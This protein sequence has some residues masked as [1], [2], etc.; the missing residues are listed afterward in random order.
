MALRP[1]IPEKR[2]P[3]STAFKK[4]RL[5]HYTFLDSSNTLRR[6]NIFTR[7]VSVHY[8]YK[9]DEAHLLPVF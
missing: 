1:I 3:T 9:L 7:A 4:I 5:R 2:T 6:V 8:T